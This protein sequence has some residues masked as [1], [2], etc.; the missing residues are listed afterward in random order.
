[1]GR[2]QV[3]RHGSLAVD[4]LGTVSSVC[5]HVISYGLCCWLHR[6]V[7]HRGASTGA[8]G[9]KNRDSTKTR[10]IPAALVA[11]RR[12]LARGLGLGS[13]V[14]DGCG[15]LSG[16]D[17]VGLQRDAKVAP[18]KQAR[19]PLTCAKSAFTT[20]LTVCGTVKSAS[21]TGRFK[22]RC[23]R[24]GLWLC[25]I[26][27]ILRRD[28]KSLRRYPSRHSSRQSIPLGEYKL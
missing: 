9:P 3:L 18:A 27:E 16:N 5:A 21:S 11:M 12:G 10:S 24:S 20:S 19:C 4:P 6:G 13:S 23:S 26:V 14:A 25:L 15:C 7:D 17:V 28:V 1:M 8:T 22:R 2:T